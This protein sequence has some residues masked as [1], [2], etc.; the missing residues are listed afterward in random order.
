MT[1]ITSITAHTT[2]E[3]QR[4]TFTYSVIDAEGN[5]KRS[6]VRKSIVVLDDELQA[7]IDALSAY[8]EERVDG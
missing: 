2:A 7:H 8:A 6:N 3:G 4:L 1:K 5:V